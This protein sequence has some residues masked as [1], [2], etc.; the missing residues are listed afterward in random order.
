LALFLDGNKIQ[1]P[2]KLNETL[3]E[4]WLP[5]DST[6]KPTNCFYFIDKNNTETGRPKAI[7]RLSYLTKI[8]D[9][10]LGGPQAKD[11]GI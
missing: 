8:K 4:K 10:G 3:K 5:F 11:Y 9:K 7:K 2:K 6:R 1:H